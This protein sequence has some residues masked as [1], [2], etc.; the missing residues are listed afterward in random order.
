[1]KRNVV[2]LV[3]GYNKIEFLSAISFEQLRALRHKGIIDRIIY[4]TWD[5]PRLDNLLTPIIATP[6]IEVVRIPEP[7]LTGAPLENSIVYQI[8]NLQAALALIADDNALVLKTRT[9]ILFLNESFLENKIVHFDE[10]CA[11]S[12]LPK[13]IGTPLPPPVFKR[14]IW[15]PWANATEPLFYNDAVFLGLKCD[16]QKL[17]DSGA[18]R[19]LTILW[20]ER[21]D[22]ISHIARFLNLFLPDYPI[23]QRYFENIHCFISTP[24]YRER[25]ATLC[26]HHPFFRHLVVLNAWLLE[27]NFHV[28]AGKNGDVV[29]C[30]NRTNQNKVTSIDDIQFAPPLTCVETWRNN[31]RPGALMNCFDFALS[32]LMDD[33]WAHTLLTSRK[34]SDITHAEIVTMLRNAAAYD[35]AKIGAMEDAFYSEA[36]A[37]YQQYVKDNPPVMSDEGVLE[38][39]CRSKKALREA[40]LAKNFMASA[41][42]LTTDATGEGR[43]V[44]AK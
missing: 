37:F 35:R 15:M 38:H 10:L 8:R 14:K 39:R 30:A 21:T 25:F 27:T 2:A 19:F 17:A 28:D 29:F 44:Q 22:R 32:Y 11:R 18:E 23:L 26:R 34:L 6:D 20:D 33:N 3:T 40:E 31:I 4:V 13:R 24:E 36:N 41:R 7:K 1:M 43:T 5:S 12:G 9:D 16:I 42:S